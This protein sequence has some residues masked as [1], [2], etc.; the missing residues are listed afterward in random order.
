MIFIINS[1]SHELAINVFSDEVSGFVACNRL[2]YY[3]EECSQCV[4]KI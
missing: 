4:Y 3:V 2:T 1:H